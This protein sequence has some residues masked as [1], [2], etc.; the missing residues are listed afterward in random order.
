MINKG[1]E[2][3]AEGGGGEA[4]SLPLYVDICSPGY[5]F[6][7]EGEGGDT[8]TCLEGSALPCAMRPLQNNGG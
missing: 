3:G 2:G 8:G 1:W 5:V 7:R 4:P 6:L